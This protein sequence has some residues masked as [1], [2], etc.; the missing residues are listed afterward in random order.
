[1]W[2]RLIL[3]VSLTALLAA[4]PA[5]A[6]QFGSNP[7]P[8]AFWPTPPETDQLRPGEIAVEVEYYR[9]ATPHDPKGIDRVIIWGCGPDR[10]FRVVRV[11]SGDDPKQE[12][13]LLPMAYAPSPEAKGSRVLVGRLLPLEDRKASSALWPD[14]DPTLR[15]FEP[16]LPPQ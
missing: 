13:I 10:V 9:L 15:Y 2:V 3:A 7:F 4:R 5:L 1:M 12:F 11:L 6:C 8:V 16:R 14:T